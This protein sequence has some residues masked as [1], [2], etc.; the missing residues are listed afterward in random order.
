MSKGTRKARAA[1]AANGTVASQ[2]A[3]RIIDRPMTD[4]VTREENRQRQYV[5]PARAFTAD[6]L[7]T[8]PVVVAE[9]RAGRVTVWRGAD[10]TWYRVG[11]SLRIQ[12]AK[13]GSGSQFKILL[14]KG[15]TYDDLKVLEREAS[16]TKAGDGGRLWV[17]RG[18]DWAPWA[19]DR[20][21]TFAFTNRTYADPYTHVDHSPRVA[22]CTM[23]GCLDQW[24]EVGFGVHRFDFVQRDLGSRGL[25]SIGVTRGTDRDD[26][27]IV[28]VY[29][30][31]FYGRA[32]D[33]ASLVNDLQWM[34]A[35]CD[36]ANAM[37][38]D[39]AA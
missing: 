28:D 17:K 5:D 18:T 10:G 29:T 23:P 20:T 25:Y 33:V 30:D 7:A 12:P 8:M 21:Y 37:T 9:S 31:E 34:R 4:V 26:Q 27:W 14:Y 36:R 39:A 15:A 11:G 2:R 38:Q 22:V 35:E 32:E 3:V 16:R 24:H 13:D 6:E 19:D 1:A